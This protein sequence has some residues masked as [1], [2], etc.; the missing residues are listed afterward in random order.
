MDPG[1][2]GARGGGGNRSATEIDW[3]S[4][5]SGSHPVGG[6]EHGDLVVAPPEGARGIRP[7]STVHLESELCRL[8]IQY[9]GKPARA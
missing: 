2:T 8:M 5:A 7:G 4:S 6:D 3:A 9:S 1:G